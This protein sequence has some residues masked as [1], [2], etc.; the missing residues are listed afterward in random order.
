MKRSKR[1]LLALWHRRRRQSHCQTSENKIDKKIESRKID[2][3]STIFKEFGVPFS[4]INSIKQLFEQPEVQSMN[5][6]GK[7]TAPQ[8]GSKDLEFPR[9]PIRFDHLK[10]AE[11]EAPPLL[12]EHSE[13]ILSEVI[14]P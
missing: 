12:G 8:Y 7:I 5:L 11:M 14:L 4:P 9:F 3:L 1:G 6:T 10:N 2:D 13:Q